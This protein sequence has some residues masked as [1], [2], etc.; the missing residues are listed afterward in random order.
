VP[1]TSAPGN[2]HGRGGPIGAVEHLHSVGE[3]EQSHRKSD[4]LAADTAG[5]PLAVP[6][7]EHLLERLA[8][9]VA[10]TKA[11]GHPRGCKA[12]RH[13][14]EFDVPPAGD[15]QVGG[16]AEPVQRRATRADMAEHEAEH[17]QAS[18]VDLIAVATEG[19]IV[20]EP[21]RNLWRVGHTSHPGQCGDVVVIEEALMSVVEKNDGTVMARLA[22][23]FRSW[24][25]QVEEFELLDA[26][27]GQVG[28]RLQLS[29]RIR[30]RP[31]PFDIGEGWHVIE[32]R[33]FADVDA[34]IDNLD[35][36]CSGFRLEKVGC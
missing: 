22:E 2:R 10:E 27:V 26:T 5:Y 8:H 34:A 24:F 12:V 23:A 36:V 31:A 20:T 3:V 7:S 18:Q 29:W 19:D 6:S 16:E 4:V 32:Q 14:A 9:I 33:A 21:R 30:V 13:H 35:L 1:T 28:G 15:Y 25:G 17:G 11:F